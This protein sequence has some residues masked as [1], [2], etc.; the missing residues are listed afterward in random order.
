MAVAIIMCLNW[1]LELG[2]GYKQYK[3]QI[4]ECQN[5]HVHEVKLMHNNRKPKEKMLHNLTF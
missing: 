1:E 2:I 5:H 3:S 4:N